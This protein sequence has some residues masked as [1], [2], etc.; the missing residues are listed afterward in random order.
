MGDE[1]K[2]GK[3]VL[4]SCEK[5]RWNKIGEKV[6]EWILLIKIGEYFH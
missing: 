3:N 5:E 2:K 4:W 6:E 1:R